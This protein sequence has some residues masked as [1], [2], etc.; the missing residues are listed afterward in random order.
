MTRKFVPEFADNFMALNLDPPRTPKVGDTV[1]WAEVPDGAMARFDIHEGN[2]PMHQFYRRHAGCGTICG[3]T[4]PLDAWA[5][6]YDE[7]ADCP[8]D[9]MF[10]I[11]EPPV[12]IITLG[13]SGSESAADLQRMAEI[14]DIRAH[15]D[16]AT[17]DGAGGCWVADEEHFALWLALPDW[18]EIQVAQVADPAAGDD[19][20]T[21]LDLAAQM[22][23]AVGW[24]A[25]MSAE[26]AALLLD[27]PVGWTVSRP[28]AG[29]FA[30]SH[31]GP[32]GHHLHKEWRDTVTQAAADAHTLAATWHEE[33]CQA[34]DPNDP[35][36]FLPAPPR[37][38]P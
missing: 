17:G 12:T 38:K 25:G 31:S 28:D 33:D 11:D 6:W 23:H 24:R 29:K 21:V 18:Q 19:F 26:D 13:L 8:W 14:F 1:A 7:D 30:A 37:R 22:L 32:K 9:K 27:L 16:A 4:V 35:R 10:G 15:L 3:V 20:W 34:A 5:Q 2:A 36:P